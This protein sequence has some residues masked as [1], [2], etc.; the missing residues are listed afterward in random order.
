[1]ADDAQCLRAALR[2]LLRRVALRIRIDRGLRWCVQGAMVAGGMLLV[3]LVIERA[4]VLLADLSEPIGVFLAG[5][6]VL[7]VHAEPLASR[8]ALGVSLLFGIIGSLRPVGR[9][10]C[11]GRADAAYGFSGTLLSALEFSRIPAERLT[12]F[13]R[14]CMRRAVRLVAT[15]APNKV[16]VI[17]VPRRVGWLA[18]VALAIGVLVLMPP[19]ARPA[20]LQATAPPVRPVTL[21]PDDLDAFRNEAGQALEAFEASGADVTLRD[22]ARALQRLLDELEGGASD[23]GQTLDQLLS[24]EQRLRER[25][26]ETLAILRAG[27]EELGRS[28]SPA[29]VTRSLAQ[30]LEA[31]N[32]AEAARA[33][34]KLK[35]DLEKPRRRRRAHE[36]ALARELA[37]AR[38]PEADAGGAALAPKQRALQREIARLLERKR[39]RPL[40]GQ[41][42]R[43]LD[44]R[45]RELAALREQA[46]REA[47]ARRTL[48]KLRRQLAQAAEHLKGGR[49]GAGHDGLQA[50]QRQLQGLA[51]QQRAGQGGR[52]LADQIAQLRRL[53]RASKGRAAGDGAH[54]PSP[55]EDQDQRGPPDGSHGRDQG[56]E[57]GQGRRLELGRFV[58]AARGQ[59]PRPPGGSVGRRPQGTGKGARRDPP[60]HPTKDSTEERE[61]ASAPRAGQPLGRAL[62]LVEG[63]RKA[64]LGIPG[65]GG[66]RASGSGGLGDDAPQ[67]GARATHRQTSGELSHVTGQQARGP[68]RSETIR[69][70]GGQGFVS[71]PYREVHAEYQ[72]HAERVIERDRVPGGYRFYVRRYFQLIRPRENGEP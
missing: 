34:R 4:L 40:D 62:P 70:A 36:R 15:V 50:A 39:D 35:E 12:P 2:P 11:A 57:P 43:L 9:L 51:D 60:E 6:P 59:A 61:R 72:K 30:P 71:A 14:A 53:L 68:T 22:H 66:A 28:L 56:H 1:M 29:R 26:S 10:A 52:Q 19:I 44:K 13:E 38:Q 64:L 31:A 27:L 25:S 67:S 18:P 63:D 69:D 41:A 32:A 17:G 55:S 33:L 23:P 8:Y 54:G 20:D 24:L 7:R 65:P 49:L 37:R 16:V 21:H 58:Q 46:Q 5:A 47:T 45:K 48:Q 3:L 42:A